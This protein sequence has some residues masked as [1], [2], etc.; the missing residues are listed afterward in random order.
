MTVGKLL[1]AGASTKAKNKVRRGGGDEERGYGGVEGQHSPLR[2]IFICILVRSLDKCCSTGNMRWNFICVIADLDHLS[3]SRPPLPEFP[4][5]FPGFSAALDFYRVTT[6]G[7]L[8]IPA[9]ESHISRGVV[10]DCK[11]EVIPQLYSHVR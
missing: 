1:E 10:V 5:M 8:A 2:V 3:K 11:C 4:I 7:S 6:R 9:V